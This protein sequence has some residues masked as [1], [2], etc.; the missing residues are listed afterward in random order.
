LFLLLTRDQR[1][2]ADGNVLAA[3][4]PWWT[5]LDRLIACSAVGQTGHMQALKA[6]MIIPTQTRL[7]LGLAGAWTLFCRLP[8]KVQFALTGGGVFGVGWLTLFL[9][10]GIFGWH[11]ATANG[12]QLGLTFTLNYLLNRH[13][14]W[15]DRVVSR[16]AVTK[17]LVSRT[18]TTV[19]N[20]YLFAWLIAWQMTIALGDH[21]WSLYIHYLL[22]NVLCVGIMAVINWF[23]SDQWV[24]AGELMP[25]QGQLFL[26]NPDQ[27]FIN[28]PV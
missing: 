15:R 11:E 13:L 8:R 24:F 14:T 18:A 1:A 12:L 27:A 6:I 10:V 20:Y 7:Y 2:R 3:T 28:K 25:H 5:A 19:A 26:V 22:A 23:T 9:L 16:S 17:F 21:I 4:E